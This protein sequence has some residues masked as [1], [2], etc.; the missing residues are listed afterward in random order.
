MERL[1]FIYFCLGAGS[2][3]VGMLLYPTL[4]RVFTRIKSMFKRKPRSV[5]SDEIEARLERLE[6][7][8]NRRESDRKNKT[9]KIVLEYLT[10]L[11]NEKE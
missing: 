9:R 2:L 10:E 4:Q 1:N 7:L 5:A 3:F 11:K 6:K 8:W